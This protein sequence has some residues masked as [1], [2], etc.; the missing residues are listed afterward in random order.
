MHH[1][2]FLQAMLIFSLLRYS[3]LRPS[4]VLFLLFLLATATAQAQAPSD[5]GPAPGEAPATSVPVDGGASAL[6]AA[7]VAFGLRRLRRLRQQR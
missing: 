2:I 3:A 7:G 5:G 4:R 6:L 1:L